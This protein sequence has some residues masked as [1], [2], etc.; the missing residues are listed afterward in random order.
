MIPTFLGNLFYP[1]GVPLNIDNIS[2]NNETIRTIFFRKCD[3]KVTKADEEI[4]KEYLVY[5]ISAPIFD[6]EF[7]QELRQKNLMELSLDDAISECI[8]YGLD[9][10]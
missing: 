7:T 8:E 2:V 4:L 1:G 6:S 3:G 5:H 9:P 10:F